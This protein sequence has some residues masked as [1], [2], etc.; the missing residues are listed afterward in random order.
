MP[1]HFFAKRIIPSLLLPLVL[2]ACAPSGSPQA[3]PKAA[4]A[5]SGST[6]IVQLP[7]F[8]VLVEKEGPSVVNISTTQT[9]HDQARFSPFP[10]M[11]PNDPFSE[12]FRRFMPPQAGPHDYQTHSL[13]SGFIISDD[14]YILT[15]RHVV[16]DASE[17]LVKL[18]DKR[19]FKAR[20]IGSDRRSDVALIKIDAKGLPKI[21]IGDS[22]KLKVGE[23]VVAIGSPFGFENSVTQGIVSAKGRSLPD[24]DYVS[25]I[26][27]D[28]PVNPGNSGGPLFNLRGEVVGINSQIYSRTGGYMGLSFAI[29]INVAMNVVDQLR[30]HGKVTRGRIGVKIQNLTPELAASFGLK[31]ANGALVSSVEKGGPA[32]KAGLLPGDVILKF[33]GKP[34]GDSGELPGL[35]V[36]TKPG[37]S[38]S[39]QILRK[40]T[41]RDVNIVIG[42]LPA[43][44]ET[45][46]TE[47]SAGA[48]HMGLAISD[49][50]PDQKRQLDVDHGVLVDDVQGAAEQAGIQPGDVILAINNIDIAGIE[51]F[52]RLISQQR[53]GA[54]IAL[55]IQRGDSTFYVALKPRP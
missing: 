21:A 37:T 7:D 18:T 2:A 40:G 3:E 44:K 42:E 17:V 33:N 16:D 32:E 53:R 10:E 6:A 41:P 30:S 54:A 24:E 52:K 38:V 4:A 36:E 27:T 12:F 5:P 9:V 29:P 49:L 23:W 19:E 46:G 14:G 45:A 15:N 28:V 51:P 35:V 50:T 47:K 34:V 11:S 48:E 39:L 25:F 31:G 26:Q 22:V 43:D 1:T 8:S 20:V 55:L 13:G